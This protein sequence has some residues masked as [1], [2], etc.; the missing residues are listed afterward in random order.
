MSEDTKL[1]GVFRRALGRARIVTGFEHDCRKIPR[2]PS[3][4]P[5]WPSVVSARR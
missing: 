4:P 5:L 2:A 1:E 3:Q